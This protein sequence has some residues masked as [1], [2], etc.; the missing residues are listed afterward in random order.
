MKGM[1]SSESVR[2]RRELAQLLRRLRAIRKDRLTHDE[3]VERINAA[4]AEAGSLRQF[5]TVTHAAD[6]G[7]VCQ[8]CRARVDNRRLSE[9]G[10]DPRADDERREA[11]P[12][13]A[14]W[15]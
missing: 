4:L 14:G 7:G 9:A 1:R 6:P 3:L 13:A 10:L 5:V 12:V 15:L 11:D 2:I 8:A